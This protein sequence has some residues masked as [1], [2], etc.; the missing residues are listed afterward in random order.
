MV[1]FYQVGLARCLVWYDWYNIYSTYPD[2][3]ADGGGE[4]ECGGA[5][6]AHHEG[7]VEEEHH[8]PEYKLADT[9]AVAS[10]PGRHPLGTGLRLDSGLNTGPLPTLSPPN[11]GLTGECP[12]TVSNMLTVFNT[13]KKIPQLTVV[14]HCFSLV[15][16]KGIFKIFIDIFI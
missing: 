14:H 10:W 5:D 12:P 13:A 1:T 8:S 16:E 15:F 4:V 2:A 7:V 3:A 11:A 9:R 6:H